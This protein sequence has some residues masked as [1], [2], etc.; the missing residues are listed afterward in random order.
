MDDETSGRLCL[1]LF[2]RLWETQPAPTS[3]GSRIGRW[4][5]SE[6]A[7]AWSLRGGVL[8]QEKKTNFGA[9]D[10][11]LVENTLREEYIIQELGT[12]N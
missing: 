1:P 2:R 8:C 5:R 3:P 4:R 7:A 10:A 6:E 12:T 11:Q 9:G